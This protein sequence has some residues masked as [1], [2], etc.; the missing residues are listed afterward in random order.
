MLDEALQTTLRELLETLPLVPEIYASYRP[1]VT[2][3]FVYFLSGL[4]Y[5]RVAGIVAEQM[6]LPEN[7]SVDDRLV[8]LLHSR[9]TLHKLGQVVGHDKRLAPEL[10][11]R[12]QSLESLE[13][14]GTSK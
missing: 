5:E 12:L 11:Q 2:D 3:G 1:L 10:R 7:T 9:P 6:R 4:S 13:Q 8:K 14:Y